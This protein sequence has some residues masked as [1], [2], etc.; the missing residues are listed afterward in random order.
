MNSDEWMDR[1]TR[2]RC[3]KNISGARQ[4]YVRVRDDEKVEDNEL[5]LAFRWHPTT[6][7]SVRYLFFVF[8]GKKFEI[9]KKYYHITFAIG[10]FFHIFVF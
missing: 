9:I 3:I 2:N 6:I 1:T 5:E 10:K 4:I 7:Q 8:L